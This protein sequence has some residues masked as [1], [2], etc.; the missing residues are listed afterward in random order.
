MRGEQA[1]RPLK[2]PRWKGSCSHSSVSCPGQLFRLGTVE[3]L[4]ER[5]NGLGP[6]PPREQLLNARV[7]GGTSIHSLG[8]FVEAVTI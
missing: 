3:R 7:L 5:G 4:R 8:S 2:T 1:C 6:P